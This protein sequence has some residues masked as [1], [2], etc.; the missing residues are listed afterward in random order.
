MSKRQAKQKQTPPLSPSPTPSPVGGLVGEE[1]RTASE[2]GEQHPSPV[3]ETLAE[4]LADFG[5]WL[6]DDRR[7]LALAETLVEDGCDA[8][9]L[10]LVCGF[11]ERQAGH[12][13][14]M[15]GKRLAMVLRPGVWQRT[16]ETAQKH[17]GRTPADES[18]ATAIERQ[19]LEEEA[20]RT[21]ERRRC[22]H[23]AS[24]WAYARLMFDQAKPRDVANE[25]GVSVDRLPAL[26]RAGAEQYHADPDQ[27]VEDLLM[28]RQGR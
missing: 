9:A 13:P 8:A 6:L 17:A 23:R 22:D 2:A 16:R 14:E 19:R 7:R 27:A 18:E 20:E 21:R 12:D 15:T 11:V 25:L 4:T 3:P 5:V 24:G 1:V 28:A 10:E 26:V